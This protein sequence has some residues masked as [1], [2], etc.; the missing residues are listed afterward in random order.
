MGYSYFRN[1]T[2][3]ELLQHLEQLILVGDTQAA[4][5]YLHQLHNLMGQKPSDW[6][7][8]YL[9]LLRSLYSEDGVEYITLS[10]LMDFT[11]ML[12]GPEAMKILSAW[13]KTSSNKFYLDNEG[14]PNICK[15]LKIQYSCSNCNIVIEGPEDI[16]LCFLCDRFFC[17]NCGDSSN[18]EGEC[19]KCL[20]GAEVARQQ[21]LQ[22][23]EASR[24]YR[25]GLTTCGACQREMDAVNGVYCNTCYTLYCPTCSPG[26]LCGVP[27][28]VAGDEYD[29]PPSDDVARY[30][31][32]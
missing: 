18:G 11:K 28:R 23:D 21:R 19:S 31:R 2:G 5:E 22:E 10:V 9:R 14:F 29:L 16:N 6:H 17:E 3:D 24:P 15:E 7:S 20:A 25:P 4:V 32:R 27:G 1:P 26:H 13:I 30:F 12:Y 8:L